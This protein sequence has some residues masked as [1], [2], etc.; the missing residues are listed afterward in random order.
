MKILGI[1]SGSILSG[2][3]FCTLNAA[4]GFI[5]NGHEVKI[6]FSGWHDGKFQARLNEHKIENIPLKLGWYYKTKPLWSI[7]S[8]V[9]YPKSLF[10]YL[11]IQRRFSPDFIFV[12]SYRPVLLLKQ[13]ISKKIIFH[14]NDPHA[15][16][17][18][19]C[20]VLSKVQ[21]KIYKFVAASQ[22]IKKDLINAGIKEHK[23][24]VVH[25]GIEIPKE[26]IKV[27]MPQNRIR[28]GIVGQVI[29]RKGHEDLINACKL[30][31]EEG[32]AFELLIFGSGF[33]GY[34]EIIKKQIVE[35]N[36]ENEVYWMG[37]EKD[38]NNIYSKLDIMV[39]PTRNEEPFALVALEAAAYKVPVIASRSGGFPESVLDN[40]TGFIVEK[41]APEKIAEKIEILFRNPSKLKIFGYNGRVNVM[42]RF[43]IEHMHQKMENVLT[44]NKQ[45]ALHLN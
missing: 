24:E 40:E 33:P 15:H 26:P 12:D 8:L 27:Y 38:L 30:L 43:T 45:Q 29:P 16:S 9:H 25:N 2:K 23:I 28:I 22:F 20:M 36:L 7:D 11:Q 6:I 17:K 10:K 34:I 14:V 42:N 5:K 4:K 13:F 39:A 32:V 35:S 19:D 41:K 21:N 31:K 1:V 37:F 3:E 18:I 44:V